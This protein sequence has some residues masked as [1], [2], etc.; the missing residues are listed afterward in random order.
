MK[1]LILLV[2]LFGILTVLYYRLKGL[3]A[4]LLAPTNPPRMLDQ[5]RKAALKRSL[6]LIRIVNCP[7]RHEWVTLTHHWHKR[8]QGYR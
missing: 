7:I 6:A 3:F 2:I 5:G 8:I 1:Y 4:S